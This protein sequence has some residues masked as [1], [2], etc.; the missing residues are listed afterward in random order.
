MLYPS[1]FK[2]LST[3]TFLKRI[4]IY[5]KLFVPNLSFYK[6]KKNLCCIKNVNFLSSN[7][8]EKNKINK[9]IFIFIIIV[10]RGK[11]TFFN[12]YKKPNILTYLTLKVYSICS[13]CVWVWV[14]VWV[15]VWGCVGVCVCVCV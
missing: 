9:H 4:L 2:D 8:H 5:L 7:R 10:Y 14:C 12:M 6:M 3:R 13:V 1:P 11:F 15:C